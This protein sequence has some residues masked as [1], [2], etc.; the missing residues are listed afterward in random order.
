MARKTTKKA[1]MKDGSVSDFDRRILSFI[2]PGEKIGTIYLSGR[3]G[4]DENDVRCSLER[5]NDAG[6]ILLANGKWSLPTV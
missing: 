4:D 6:L 3:T 1:K 5:L 2:R